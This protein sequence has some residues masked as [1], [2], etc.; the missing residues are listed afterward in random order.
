V[1]LPVD[2]S[3]AWAVVHLKLGQRAARS[4]L[5]EIAV[6]VTV[7][8]TNPGDRIAGPTDRHFFA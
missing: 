1:S 8:V 4:I 2:N 3:A 7:K 6:A 5:E